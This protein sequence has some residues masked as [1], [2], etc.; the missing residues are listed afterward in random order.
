MQG[1]NATLQKHIAKHI[2]IVR[3]HFI[4]SRDYPVSIFQALKS[5]TG[6]QR[7]I[8]LEHNNNFPKFCQKKF[9]QKI[10]K[11]GVIKIWITI[12]LTVE[13]MR[14][15]II[16]PWRMFQGHCCAKN[17]ETFKKDSKNLQIFFKIAD[18]KIWENIQLNLEAM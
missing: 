18:T 8:N 1:F 4:V 16:K 17:D 13:I 2:K 5:F 14:Q 11:A 3:N 9:S 7:S 15:L 6:S 10:A 12:P